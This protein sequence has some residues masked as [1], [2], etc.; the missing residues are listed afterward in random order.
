MQKIF[1][2]GGLIRKLWGVETHA[3]RDHLLRLDPES[4][5]NRFC[6]AIADDTIRSY[7]ATARGADVI[8][9]GFFVDGV[10][11]GAADLRI[12]R[13]LDRQEAEAA[14]SIE[15]RWQSHGVGS[16]LLER[17]LLA[18]RNRGIKH[19]QVCCLAQNHRMQKL[20]HKFE[21]EISF[22]FGT[23]V[24]MMENSQ[25]SPLSLMQ[26]MVA[27][28]HSFA[29]AYVDFQS[30]LFRPMDE[31]AAPPAHPNALPVQ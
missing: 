9:H 5:R 18:A 13:P 11:R 23:L 2:E 26:E 7:A 28:G 4:H 25:P 10:L 24:G 14:F 3:Y 12:V 16:A 8:V 19:L 29:A 21:A 31:L 27:D 17:T 20:A 15:K 1:I 6:G 22:D 30:R